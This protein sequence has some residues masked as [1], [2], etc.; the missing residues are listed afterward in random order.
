MF[1]EAFLYPFDERTQYNLHGL[2]LSSRS[3]RVIQPT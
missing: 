2:W 1:L 3:L